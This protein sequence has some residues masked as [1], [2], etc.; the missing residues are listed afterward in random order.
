MCFVVLAGLPGIFALGSSHDKSIS[1]HIMFL[2]QKQKKG[3]LFL[4]HPIFSYHPQTTAKGRKRTWK[5]LS[6]STSSRL[7]LGFYIGG[8]FVMSCKVNFYA[9]RSAWHW[10]HVHAEYSQQWSHLAQIENIN[11]S[12]ST[13]HFLYIFWQTMCPWL[14]LLE[15]NTRFAMPVRVRN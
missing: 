14:R 2:E 11:P 10:I 1:F 3:R 7:F 13:R 15:L 12:Q 4:D 9:V 6:M 5:Q 8:V